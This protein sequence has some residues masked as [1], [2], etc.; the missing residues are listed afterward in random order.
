MNTKNFVEPRNREIEMFRWD[1]GYAS[2]FLDGSEPTRKIHDH[3]RNI[4][5]DLE[6]K[7]TYF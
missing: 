7:G 1:V 5:L 2:S 6:L 3:S 4:E